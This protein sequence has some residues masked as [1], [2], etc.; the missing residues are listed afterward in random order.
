MRYLLLFSFI[1]FHFSIH[2]QILK[3][4][5]SDSLS[6]E[7]LPYA[8]LVLKGKN[9]GTY[10]N[11]DG[12]YSLNI[13]KAIIEDTLAV[14]LIGYHYKKIALFQFIDTTEPKYN[15]QLIPKTEALNEILLVDNSKEYS[16]NTVKLLTGNQYLERSYILYLLLRLM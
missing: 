1:L 6:K 4:K 13:S 3:G 5:I 12:S 9:I 14:S 15:F 10:S 7:N 11:E 8:N 2:A 16:G